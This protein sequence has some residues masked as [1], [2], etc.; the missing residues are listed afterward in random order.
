[1]DHERQEKA[2]SPQTAFLG[3]TYKEGMCTGRCWSADTHAI[4]PAALAGS[5]YKNSWLYEY[6]RSLTKST[7]DAASHSKR[8][9]GFLGDLLAEAVTT[10]SILPRGSHERSSPRTQEEHAD[11]WVPE[12]T[13][14]ARRPYSRHKM[15]EEKGLKNLTRG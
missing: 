6:L 15:Y 4:P 8:G 14:N 1:M 3:D 12:S 13:R 9:N 7:T 2:L 5:L 11:K 10:T